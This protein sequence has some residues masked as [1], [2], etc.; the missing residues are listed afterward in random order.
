M[1]CNLE[2]GE[3]LLISGFRKFRV[4]DKNKRRGR[5]PQTGDDLQENSRRVTTFKCSSVLKQ[6]LNKRKKS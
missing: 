3:D 4:K 2:S 1:M 5:N 6:K